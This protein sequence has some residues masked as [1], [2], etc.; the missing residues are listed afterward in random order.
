MLLKDLCVQMIQFTQCVGI[1][2]KWKQ[3]QLPAG[4]AAG[5]NFVQK[6]W[7]GKGSQNAEEKD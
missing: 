4:F 3:D 7:N 5:S 2:V 6:G 1:V